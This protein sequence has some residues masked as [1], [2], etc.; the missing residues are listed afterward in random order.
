MVGAN[1]VH[2]SFQRNPYET[3]RPGRDARL[4]FR[5]RQGVARPGAP[6]RKTN[7]RTGSGG[8]D[9]ARHLPPADAVNNE[10]IS[11]AAAF[12]CR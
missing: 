9:T 7:A 3:A 1:A 10:N 6:H 11:R 2:R 12:S 4:S 5:S 8:P